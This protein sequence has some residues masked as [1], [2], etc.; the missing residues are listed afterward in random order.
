MKKPGH[1]NSGEFDRSCE[2]YK[3]D[4]VNGRRN[5][6]IFYHGVGKKSIIQSR[7]NHF[8]A[9]IDSQNYRSH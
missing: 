6:P 8:E 4:S 2:E 9:P 5:Q 7:E 1:V 3:V